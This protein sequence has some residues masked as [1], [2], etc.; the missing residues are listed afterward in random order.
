VA[1]YAAALPYFRNT[2]LSAALFLPILFSRLSLVPRAD[3]ALTLR[4]T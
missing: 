3:A 4:A 1:C 2:L